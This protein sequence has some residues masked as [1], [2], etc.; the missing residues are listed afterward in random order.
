LLTAKGEDALPSGPPAH[1]R[2][3]K[4]QAQAIQPAAVGVARA[5]TVRIRLKPTPPARVILRERHK[6]RVKL[7]VSFKPSG[8]PPET[9]SVPVVLRL[10]A[11]PHDRR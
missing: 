8:S 9:M 3:L 11:R 1:A 10:K 4:K 6:L 5:G 7:K 2:R